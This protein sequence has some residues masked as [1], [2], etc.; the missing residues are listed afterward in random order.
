MRF[1]RWLLII[2]NLLFKQLFIGRSYPTAQPN[3]SNKTENENRLLVRNATFRWDHSPK[4]ILENTSEPTISVETVGFQITVELFRVPTAPAV[5]G[6]TGLASSGKTS[7]VHALLAQMPLRSGEVYSNDRVAYYPE[8]P[9]L[10]ENGTLRQNICWSNV[11]SFDASRYR[12]CLST[13]QLHLNVGYDLEPMDRSDLDLQWLQKISLA[14]AIY[15]QWY[16]IIVN[17]LSKAN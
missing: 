1:H 8:Q 9:Y 6:I 12:T 15:N 11:G 14:R 2:V 3:K 16:A 7:V 17:R 10:V 4:S 5:I 13:V